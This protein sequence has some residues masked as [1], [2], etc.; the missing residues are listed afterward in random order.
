MDYLSGIVHHPERYTRFGGTPLDLDSC[1]K[2]YKAFGL[3]RMNLPH[4]LVPGLIWNELLHRKPD[5]AR[6]DAQAA[7]G[8]AQ[9]PTTSIG[10]AQI[11]IRNL[12]SLSKKYPELQQF[13]DPQKAALDPAKAPF[14]VAAYLANEADN[15]TNYNKQHSKEPG[16]EPIPVN[17]DTLAYRYNPDVYQDQD[18]HFRSLEPWEKTYRKVIGPLPEKLQDCP[19]P[20]SEVLQRSHHLQK[21]KE[22]RAD[23]GQNSW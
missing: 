16:F 3:D 19:W 7:K 20:T 11:Q 4:D 1:E 18:G 12:E 15:I 14:F 9:D 23:L 21:V 13:G 10:A 17:G 5:D 6:Q 2:A 22:A 8:E